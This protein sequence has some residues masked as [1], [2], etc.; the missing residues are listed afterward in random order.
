VKI[1]LELDIKPTFYCPN[2]ACDN[3]VDHVDIDVCPDC[4]DRLRQNA[5]PQ[6]TVYSVV[7]Q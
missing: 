6:V 5:T 4:G 1:Q 7:A 2:E 3:N